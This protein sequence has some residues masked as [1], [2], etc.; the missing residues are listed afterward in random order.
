LQAS[1]TDYDIISTYLWRVNQLPVIGILGG[2]QLGRMLI[3][4]AINYNLEIHTLDPDPKAPAAGISSGFNCGDFNDYQS[5]I[6]FG[7][8][9]DL[10]TVEIEHV[11]TRALYELEQ[12]GKMV[13]PQPRVLEMIQDKGLQKQFF[14]KHGIPSAPFRL[15]EKSSD[16]N[17]VPD[18]FFPCFQKLRKSGYDGK[19]VQHLRSA[20]DLEKAFDAPSVIEKAIDI[21]RE[22]SVIVAANGKGEIK[23]FPLVDMVFHPEANLVEFL[24]S[25]SALDDKL[26]REATDLALR[27]AQLTGI[28]G[29]LAVE[30]FADKYGQILVNE[31][32]PRPHNSGHQSIEGN[33]V[34][35]FEQ[36]LRA[37]L[38]WPLGNTAV[39]QPSVMLNL[40]GEPGFEGPAV[41]SG[42]EEI[43]AVSGVYVHLYGKKF[44]R[45][46]RKMGHITVTGDSVAE[47]MEKA[48]KV[49]NTIRVI[50]AS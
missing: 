32:A 1:K 18:D 42:L 25:P 13:F 2:G 24:S 4:A 48:Q 28:R 15:I 12:K 11:N 38:G 39:I 14:E 22:I 17:A 30:M 19:G 21:D 27:I 7:S 41:Y 20:Q 8:D 46:Y 10:I 44:T 43:I 3:Q 26:Q 6:D 40:L 5:V 29:L 33:C 37:I 45:P 35:Q 36:H 16:F 34:S 9:K 31:L 49:K 47:A 23:A 50:S